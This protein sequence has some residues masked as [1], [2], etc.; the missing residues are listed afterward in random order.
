M[1]Q[2]VDANGCRFHV[3]IDGP[4]GAPWL[5]L[6][7][8][9]GATL[10]MWR[11]QVAAF[12]RGFRVLRY[13]T[14]GH[15]ASS[16]TDGP[17]TIARLGSDVLG[18]LDALGVERAGYC[19]LSMGGA[20]GIWLAAHAPDRFTRMVFC[21]TLPWLGPPETMHS[22][23]LAVL[24]EG[25]E[26]LAD[27]TM[28]RWF[29]PE[30]RAHDPATVQEIRRQLLATSVAGYVACC[31]ALRDYD[32]RASL[33]GIAV[34][35]MIVAGTHDPAP[36]LAAARAFAALLPGAALVELPA[37]HLTNLGATAPFNAAVLRFLGA[38]S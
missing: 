33:A 30:F 37:A 10:D 7:H 36:P 17:Y 26:P 6:S 35:T 2:L 24:R 11:P 18:L 20:T 21:N 14:R 25:L 34:P 9:L 3:E 31:A 15:G 28:E 29:T 5:V 13:D 16:V 27:A 22:R 19:G 32:E 1:K 12:A 4:D 38:S 8:S 23:I